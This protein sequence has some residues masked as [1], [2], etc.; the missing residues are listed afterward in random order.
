MCSRVYMQASDKAFMNKWSLY[1][2]VGFFVKAPKE[3]I[4]S[5]KR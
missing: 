1:K 4:C 3:D 2:Y 5:R